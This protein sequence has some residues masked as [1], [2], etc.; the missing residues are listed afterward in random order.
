MKSIVKQFQKRAEEVK[1]DFINYITDTS[2]SLEDR[3][4]VFVL[5]PE[6]GEEFSSSSFLQVDSPYDDLYMERGSRRDTVDILDTLI[7]EGVLVHDKEIDD[8]KESILE[9]NYRFYVYD[10]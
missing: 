2:I 1:S 10:W 7:T 8:A 3:W 6:F 5:A 4:E 9:S